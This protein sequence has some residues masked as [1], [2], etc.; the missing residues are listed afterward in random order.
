MKSK[1]QG[2]RE[3]KKGHA[4]SAGD[5]SPRRSE[6]VLQVLID[7][8]RWETMAGLEDL[9]LETGPFVHRAARGKDGERAKRLETIAKGR[10][11]EGDGIRQMVK[12]ALEERSRGKKRT[13]D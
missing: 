2:E 4:P 10:R 12:F 6:L 1:I 3:K 9:V 11:G 5:D 8:H 7:G 13:T